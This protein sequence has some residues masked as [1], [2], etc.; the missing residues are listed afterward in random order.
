LA[1]SISVIFSNFSVASPG[2]QDRR[3][4]L[5]GEIG[6]PPTT[7]LLLGADGLF[8]FDILLSVELRQSINFGSV[9]D[10]NLK[11]G[12]GEGVIGIYT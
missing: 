7:L 11:I 12:S 4:G 2:A 10:N 3:E 9:S 5:M 8:R 1:D 6:V